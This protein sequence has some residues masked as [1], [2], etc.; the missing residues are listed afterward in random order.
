MSHRSIE[1]F[2]ERYEAM[3]THE[4]A[5]LL[6]RKSELVPEAGIALERILSRR[7]MPPADVPVQTN[8]YRQPWWSGR[9]QYLLHGL[10]LS[11]GIG[12]AREIEAGGALPDMLLSC[13]VGLL[14]WWL[15]QRL[16]RFVSQAVTPKWL[17]PLVFAVLPVSYFA[18]FAFVFAAMR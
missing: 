12:L 15:S 16:F 4:L 11:L 18:F 8:S 13:V 10:A 5:E 9:T 3:A 2:E 6:N 17:R 14:C 7:D 1:S